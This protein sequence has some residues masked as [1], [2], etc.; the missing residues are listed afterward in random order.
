MRKK[1]LKVYRRALQLA[2]SGRHYGWQ[3]I[4]TELVREGYQRAPD[5]LDGDKIRTIL[6]LRCE[7]SVKARQ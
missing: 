1:S 4:E 7:E 5:L 2:G 3:S 6:D